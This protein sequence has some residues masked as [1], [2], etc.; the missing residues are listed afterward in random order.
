MRVLKIPPSTFRNHCCSVPFGYCSFPFWIFN[1]RL[2]K[3][4]EYVCGNSHFCNDD[5]PSFICIP[6][7]GLVAFWNFLLPYFFLCANIAVRFTEHFIKLVILYGIPI[8]LVVLYN[9]IYLRNPVSPQ[10][11]EPVS[12]N[13]LISLIV[14]DINNQKIVIDTKEILYFSANSPYINIHHQT[15]KYLYTGTLRNMENRLDTSTFI[16]IHRSYIINLSKVDLY[17]SRQNGDYDL[18]LS[19]GTELRVSRN[20]AAAFKTALDKHSRLTI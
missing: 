7:N 3:N 6:G 9:T 4:K 18:K 2:Q 20:Y 15:K 10:L 8:P 19:D 12:T 11:V 17:T 16:R 13:F 1:W 5:H 14:S